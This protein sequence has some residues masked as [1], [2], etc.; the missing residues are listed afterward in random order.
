MYKHL[1][2]ASAHFLNHTKIELEHNERIISFQ[3]ACHKV[4]R[5]FLVWWFGRKV[6]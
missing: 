3:L 1:I 6:H 5:L 4:L 2:F